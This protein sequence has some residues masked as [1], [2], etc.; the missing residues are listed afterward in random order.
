MAK[1][2]L[3]EN[4]HHETDALLRAVGLEVERHPGALDEDELI[5]ALDGVSVLGIRSK[6]RV[7]GRVLAE[8]PQLEAIGT[9]SIG[10]TQ[11]DLK[12]ATRGGVAV[13]NAPFSNTRSVV[14]LAIA[15]I[16]ALNR[17]LTERD[18]AL[19]E[20]R[21]EKS[22]AGAHEVRGLTLGIIGYGNIGTQL[23]VVAE[24]LGMG[25]L[26]FDVQERP[27]LGNAKRC[28]TMEEV[29]RNSDVISIHVDDSPSN[30]G[31]IGASEF[32][33]MRQGS[34]FLN[35]SRGFVVDVEALRDAIVEGHIAGAAV[36]VY[37]EE[38]KEN[39]G[40]F[41][42]PLRGLPNV[43]LTPHIGGS[44]LEAQY[45]IGQ[46]V[47]NKL[48]RYAQSASTDMSVNLPRISLTPSPASRF[49]VAWVHRN[50]PGVLAL[51]NQTF[52]ESGANIAGQILGTVQEIGYMVTDL[53]SEI[54][55]EALD[56]LRDMEGTI[57][58][59]ILERH[60]RH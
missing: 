55:P 51:M 26:F 38:P 9:F 24:A 29:I 49:R 32:A 12:R 60:P 58:L 44:T 48:A 3:L 54:P 11:I 59:R 13:F 1:A 5:E 42:S 16:I 17:R 45:E 35:L 28:R 30:T 33:Q 27:A 39:G 37:P 18:R 10:T 46:F 8:H 14:E 50:M 22:A 7:T 25:V 15:E 47:G 53:S 2:L 4:P 56:A 34:L 43:I 31:L 40:D 36:D 52:A 20:G 21:W 41:A 6:T 23:S 19:H 57:R